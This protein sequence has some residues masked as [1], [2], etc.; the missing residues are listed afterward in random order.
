MN[1]GEIKA[2]I[3]DVYFG[4]VEGLHFLDYCNGYGDGY[5]DCLLKQNTITKQ[6]HTRLYEWNNQ[7]MDR[8]YTIAKKD[9]RSNI[10]N[11]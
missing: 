2:H 7:E 9:C 4:F 11:K 3:K 8:W 6:Q 5:I 10:K 1:T